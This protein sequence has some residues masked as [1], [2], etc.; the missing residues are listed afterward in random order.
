MTA[1]RKE[2][3]LNS[4]Q[5]SEQREMFLEEVMEIKKERLIQVGENVSLLFENKK[6]I[7]TRSKKN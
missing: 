6:I 7:H 3:L 2:D 5:Y 1:L 4:E